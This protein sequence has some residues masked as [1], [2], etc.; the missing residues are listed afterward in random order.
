LGS[1]MP[2]TARLVAAVEQ[3]DVQRATDAFAVA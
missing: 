3:R 2:A 1:V